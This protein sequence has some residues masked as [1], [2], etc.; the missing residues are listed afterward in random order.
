MKKFYF[1]F[2]LLIAVAVCVNA[3]SRQYV[4]FEHFTQA[5]C[6]PCADQNPAFQ[7][8]ILADNRGNVH[9]IAYHTSWPG[10][11]PMNAANPTPVQN[12]VD[13]YGVGGV[14]SMY[15]NGTDKGG[16]AGV[17]QSDVTNANAELAPIGIIVTETGDTERSVTIE[18]K[19]TGDIS[20]DYA[21]QTAVVEREVNYTSA[22]GSNG[23]KD[24]PNVFRATLTGIGETLTLAPI[25]ESVTLN[26]TYT[27]DDSWDAEEVYVIA[28]VQNN[29]TKQVINSG[30]SD[31]PDYAF[32]SADN[33]FKASEAAA[34]VNFSSTFNTGGGGF[35]EITLVSSQ[36]EDWTAT[37]E[38]SGQTGDGVMTINTAP[39]Q[40]LT[41]NLIVDPSIAPA[42]GDYTIEVEPFNNETYSA[43]RVAF[44]V[45]S[46]VWDLVVSND[47][48][49]GDGVDYG[50]FAALYQ[51][52]LLA[53]DN[54][55][56]A[57]MGTNAFINGMNSGALTG[58]KNIYV[59]MGWS[60]PSLTDEKV[61]AFEAFL[62]AGGN[63]L[64]AGQD[65]G[66]ETS[67]DS[68][69]TPATL[70][71]Y[72]NYMHAEYVDDG[73]TGNATLV[74]NTEDAYFGG[75]GEIEIDDIYGGNYYPDEINP[76]SDASGIFN[77][78]AANGG[79][80]GIRFENDTYKMVYLGVGLEMLSGDAAKND[81]M[82]AVHTFFYEG[83]DVDPTVDPIPE[84]PAAIVALN[85][86]G[87]LSVQPNP[88]SD[89]V[90]L[91]F[92]DLSETVEVSFFDVTGK[93]VTTKTIEAGSNQVSLAVQNWVAGAYFYQ[94]SNANKV[95]AN[96]KLMVK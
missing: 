60:F 91:A 53:I 77:Y 1:S 14:P 39:N 22:P 17:S 57:T 2:L 12:R 25:G 92:E 55:Y 71:F 95:V 34:E 65:I 23:E 7:D 32:Y 18:I 8:N 48:G 37:M 11:D 26:Y 20:G 21:L 19:T 81:F 33:R 64:I 88:A 28:F 41:I 42:V 66:W 51:D 40:E 29:A 43:Q 94:I 59:N 80:A 82:D 96:G 35:Y 69:A 74:A 31:D 5:S 84:P 78:N 10:T 45:I 54:K 86:L 9:H 38:I 87:T 13:Y 76:T 36:P 72:E 56:T 85:G 3:Q 46:N 44:N 49:F 6:G 75:L 89:F 47:A 62:D 61:A 67:S 24:F 27:I 16:P 83:V 63:M 50:S 70:S 90:T 58:V 79:N 73:G 15:M 52:G 30:S 68:Y 93:L 4:V